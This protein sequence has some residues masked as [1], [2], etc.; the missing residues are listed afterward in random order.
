MKHLCS[1]F[2]AAILLFAGMIF[3]S[4]VY[5][6]NGQ[7][8]SEKEE[9]EHK[10]PNKWPK[11]KITSNA[12]TIAPPKVVN[13]KELADYEAAH[14]TVKHA[15]FIEQGEDKDAEFKFIPK[16][17]PAGA[18]VTNIPKP[19]HPENQNQPLHNSPA[20]SGS[21]NGVMDDGSTIPPDIQGAAGP[22]YIM[23]TT[24]QQFNIYTKSGVLTSQLALDGF[25][26]AT[27]AQG[28][29]DPHI[30]YDPNYSKFIVC[31]DAFL[32][33]G[34]GGLVLAVSQT[35]DPTGNWYVYTIDDGDN[36]QNDLLDYP[37]MGFNKNWIVLTAN[38]FIGNSIT[39]QIYVLNRASLYSGTLGTVTNFT[40]NNAYTLVP[41]QTYDINQA[42]EYLVQD[43]NGNSGGSGY[44]QIGTITGTVNAPVYNSGSTIGVNQPWDENSVSATQAGS[45]GNTIENG[46]TRVMNG[47]AYINNSL[48][49]THNVFLPAGN[50]TY[51]GVD[52]LQVNPASMAVTQFGRVADPAGKAFYYY[53]SLNVN[54]NGDALLGYCV[55]SIDSFYASAAYSFHAAADAPN[56]MQSRYIYKPGQ[57]AYFKDFGGGRNR[58]GDYT[59]TA[60]DPN[61]NSFWNFGQWAQTGNNWGTVIAHVSASVPP[62]NPPVANFSSNEVSNNCS[63]VIQFTDLS[64]NLPTSWLWNFGDGGTSTQQ[65]PSHEYVTNG[66]YTV[67]LK[68]TNTY[69][70]GT[71]ADTNYITINLPAPP[72]AAN[73][74]H[75]GA[76]TF[77]LSASTSNHVAW[78]DSTGAVVSTS[79]P[80]VT[81]QLN[82]TTIYWVIDT[83]PGVVDSLGLLNNNANAYGG[84]FSNS[85][86]RYLIFDAL[87][88][89]TL[90]SVVVYAQNGG[91]RTI[92]LRDAN[93]NTIQSVSPNLNNGQNVVTLNFNVPAGTS[94]QLGV[95]G[96]SNLYRNNPGSTNGAANINYPFTIPGIVSLKSS[97]AGLGYYYYFYNWKIKGPACISG[98]KA[99]T[100]TVSTGN[101]GL[102]VTAAA[103]TCFGSA[104][105]SVSITATGGSAPYSYSWNNSQNADTAIHLQAGNYSVT[106]TDAGGCS[107]SASAVVT[108][109]DSIK[110]TPT[111]TNVKCNGQSNGAIVNNITG[112]TQ[113]YT[114]N[115]GGGITT[116]NRNNLTAG[117]YTLTVTDAHTCTITSI[118]TVTQ[119]TAMHVSITTTNAGC[120]SSA[121]GSAAV[122]V[123][124]GTPGYIYL[125]N[126]NTTSSALSGLTGGLYIVT[127]TDQHTCTSVD[128]AAISNSG[129]LSL[130]VSTSQA[131]CFG[132][133]T[134]SAGAVVTGDTNVVHYIWSNGDTGASITN[135]AAGLYTVTASDVA[136]CSAAISQS[137]L[138]PDS[139]IISVTPV[140][141]GCGIS[142]GSATASASGGTTSYSYLWNNND[143]TATINNIGAGVYNV[144]VMDAHHCMATGGA[145][146]IST[147]SL[148][149]NYTVGNASCYGAT[150]GNIS[151]QVLSGTAPYT[152]VWN[153]NDTTTSLSNLSAG[154]YTLTITDGSHCQQINTIAINQPSQISLATG[155]TNSICADGNSG[156][157]SASATG[158]T[159]NYF[160]FWSNGSATA[161]IDS[162]IEGSYTVTV[163]DSRGCSATGG[164]TLSAPPAMQIAITVINATN[165]QNN[166]SAIIDSITGGTAPY[167]VIGWS[168]G[169]G[170][171]T[172]T[173]LAAGNYSVTVKDHSGCK[174]TAS[175]TVS[176]VTGIGSISGNLAFSIY[177]NPAKGEMTIDFD[178]TG[179]ETM[180]SLKNVLGQTLVAMPV[181]ANRTTVDISNYADGVYLIELRQGENKAVREIIFGQ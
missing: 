9:K 58:W 135:I 64:S 59:G 5:C 181:T 75:C 140:N 178:N 7:H 90:Q 50:P 56:T 157:A 132:T 22:V 93:G 45:T 125:W 35:S 34:D 110:I 173:Y 27:N 148:V 88:P 108:Q 47:V 48:W 69:G 10:V 25:Y 134:G 150:D 147:S 138:Q 40:D 4:P 8:K 11:Q 159:P 94:L 152:Y 142:N 126:N 23:E 71:L 98:R 43:A 24:N 57:A 96:T 144:T 70:S 26:S 62:Q 72:N 63:G 122:H 79:N 124:G 80:F 19:M 103:A 158:G 106:V 131:K 86:D 177:P 101:V 12:I 41:A 30:L 116:K 165:G 51:S 81:P 107:A 149:A 99:V 38:D 113:G 105:G 121:T 163:V 164:V 176:N 168:N 100:A 151:V 136:G 160:Y 68:A 17:I 29:F 102:A 166:G 170:T 83:V 92:A 66:V 52:W 171:D 18:P 146:I 117:I 31:T 180:L 2:P 133:A 37:E 44:M 153:N 53:P 76:S 60:V 28:Y 109:P 120:G 84:Y 67:I 89:F 112:G 123:L 3:A 33:N 54:S 65:N 155:F 172:A 129:S 49:F 145:N 174:E 128:T 95:N 91:V 137:V 154:N 6:E 143:T 175:F 119:P 1:A 127:V 85:T 87:A 130:S 21:F 111:I 167:Q 32:A 39:E 36:N 169:Q 78:F 46:D 61:D 114:Y 20:P 141:A 97:D 16:K 118:D 77:S 179:K 156:T 115:W 162:L 82:H 13:F 14:P 139:L 74:A 55:S 73:V 104:T 42:T 15:R 161:G